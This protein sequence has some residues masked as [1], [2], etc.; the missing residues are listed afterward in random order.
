[1]IIGEKAAGEA[2]L[3]AKYSRSAPERQPAHGSDTAPD[4]ADAVPQWGRRRR[5]RAWRAGLVGYLSAIEYAGSFFL[6]STRLS[7][8]YFGSPVVASYGGGSSPRI[9]GSK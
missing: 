3:G 7:C 9:S 5:R 6:T 8:V 4:G 1:M 2:N